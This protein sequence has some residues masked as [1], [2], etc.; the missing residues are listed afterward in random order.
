MEFKRRR[1]KGRNRQTYKE[2]VSD[3]GFFRITWTDLYGLK[4]YH[5]CVKVE[6]PT[7]FRWD[8]ALRRGPH[9]T[10]KKAVE[11]CEK[12]VRLWEAFI[13]LSHSP[14][15][16]DGKLLTLR[17]RAPEVFFYLP[18]WVR[19][20]ADSSLIQMLFACRSTTNQS[21]DTEALKSADS[22]SSLPTPPPDSESSTLDSG[23]AS[24]VGPTDGTTTKK[25]ATSSKDTSSRR[26]TSAKPATE[27]AE[28]PKK[29]SKRS[30]TKTAKSTRKSYNAGVP[31]KPS[32]KAPSESS[33]KRKG[34]R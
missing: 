15:R 19:D 32:V 34:K 16:R 30:T 33:P 22:S 18:L 27:P 21:D 26:S 5:A 28:A 11:S 24:C 6:C 4:H 12:S 14:G 1:V 29:R 25:T 23:P 3:C 7:G 20:K 13:K 2:W 17:A 9:K 31:K 8:F 10:F